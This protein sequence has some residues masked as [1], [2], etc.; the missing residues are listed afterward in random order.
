MAEQ[1]PTPKSARITCNGC[2]GSGQISFFRGVSR[3]VMDWDDCPDCLGTGY[4][5][6]PATE[7]KA[8]SQNNREIPSDK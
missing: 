5:E 2:G 6:K 7:P 1:Q 4:I 8:G 3:F